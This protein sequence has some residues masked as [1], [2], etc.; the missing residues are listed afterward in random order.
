MVGWDGRIAHFQKD[1]HLFFTLLDDLGGCL[2]I[3][4][5]E[6]ELSDGKRQILRL[7]RGN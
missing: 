1:F 4:M 3:P 7:Q 2:L 5:G 6:I